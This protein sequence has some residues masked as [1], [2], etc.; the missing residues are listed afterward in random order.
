MIAT[1]PD[2]RPPPRLRAG[3]PTW[4]LALLYPEQ[5]RWSEEEYFNLPRGRRVEYVNGFLEVLPMPV[6]RHEDIMS[7]LFRLLDAF[8]ISRRLGNV[9]PAG[10]RVGVA[11]RTYRIPD[12][13]FIRTAN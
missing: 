1:M 12:I 2:I 13:T 3:Q 9:Y 8:V 10:M 11:S 4:D 6:I 5:G 7:Y